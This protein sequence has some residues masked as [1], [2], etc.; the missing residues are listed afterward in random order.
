MSHS[1]YTKT[2]PNK[3][4]GRSQPADSERE[5][6]VALGE[7]PHSGVAESNLEHDDLP[8]GVVIVRDCEARQ[9]LDKVLAGRLSTLSRSRLQALIKTGQV[10]K[11][12]TDPKHAA[13]SAGAASSA[14]TSSDISSKPCLDPAQKVVAGERYE[15]II[16]NL[17]EGEPKPE[18]MALEILYEDDH[19]IVVNK[20]AGLVVHPAPGHETG[21]LVNGLLAHCGD[22]LSGIGGVRRPGIVHRLDKDTSGVMVV[23]KS[24]AAHQG[25][26]EQFQ[27]HGR[28]GRLS[29]CYLALV[30]GGPA[31]PKAS[32]DAPLGRSRSNRQKMEVVAEGRGRH[33]ITHYTVKERYF[34]ADGKEMAS[35]LACELETGRTHQ[36]RVHLAYKGFPVLGDT[37]YGAGYSAS[38]RNLTQSQQQALSALGRQALHAVH[39]GFEHPISRLSLAFDAPLPLDL[40]NLAATL[41]INR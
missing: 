20:P 36:I 13:D 34:N 25:L 24:D 28:D 14:S 9:R 38:A 7:V 35:L 26:S 4:S 30:W 5:P 15:V 2:A 3:Q 32:I 40:A 33:A 37:T 39:L 10:Y 19:V 6:E 41:A 22:T 16:P 8:E 12:S 29:R 18:V 21:T 23:A 11:T 31:F 27:L 1:K 17:S